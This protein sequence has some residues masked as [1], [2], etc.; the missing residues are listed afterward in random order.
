[1]AFS[2]TQID[3]LEALVARMRAEGY[4]Y[5]LCHQNLNTGIS[6]DPDMIVYFSKEEITGQTGYK[7]S[8]SADSLCYRIRSGNASTNYNTNRYYYESVS[9]DTTV[10]I[11]ES[12]HISTNAVFLTTQ[13]QPDYC[14]EVHQYETQGGILFTLCVF[15]LLYSFLKLFRR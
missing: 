9:K 14:L 2:T 13:I 12:I 1:M 7:Y 5:Y 10:N 15:L 4:T 11:E 6:N 3:L 8:V